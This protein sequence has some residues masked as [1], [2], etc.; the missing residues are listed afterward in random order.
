MFMILCQNI[1]VKAQFYF[2]NEKL[3][4]NYKI[5]QHERQTAQQLA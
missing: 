2:S 1:D 4:L 5:W 3:T